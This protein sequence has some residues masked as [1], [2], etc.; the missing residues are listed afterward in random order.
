[1]PLK[2]LQQPLQLLKHLQQL[3]LLQLILHLQ[4]GLIV[5]VFKNLPFFNFTT[6]ISIEALEEGIQV[7]L[8]IAL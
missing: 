6:E 1:M 7:I 5:I 8:E 3:L 4:K 2:H